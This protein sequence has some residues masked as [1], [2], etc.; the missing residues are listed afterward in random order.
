MIVVLNYPS[1]MLLIFLLFAFLAVTLSFSFILD[2]FLCVHIMSKLLSSFPCYK[3]QLGHLLLKVI[4]L[5]SKDPTVTRNRCFNVCLHRMLYA[6]SYCVLAAP[7][8]KLVVYRGF[9]CLYWTV[10]G[11]WPE[12]GKCALLCLWNETSHHLHQK[13]SPVKHSGWNMCYV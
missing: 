11:P 5:W 12:G 10:F 1:Y 9:P 4:V 3:S 6:V 8:F 2:E 7:S 13:W